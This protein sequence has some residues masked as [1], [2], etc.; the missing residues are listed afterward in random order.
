MGRGLR[1]WR[2]ERRNRRGR[3]RK[4]GGMVGKRVG[5]GRTPSVPPLFVYEIGR[6]GL[7]DLKNLLP[8]PRPHADAVVS[9]AAPSAAATAAAA[10]SAAL[11]A[12]EERVQEMGGSG[13]GITSGSSSGGRR[14][15]GP[16]GWAGYHDN[17]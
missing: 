7:T 3:E 14:G 9:P 5:R 13:I 6:L 17:E 2:V 1:R 10:A 15:A 4:R 11:R 8:A 12:E 16:G